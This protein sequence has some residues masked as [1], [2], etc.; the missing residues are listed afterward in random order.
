VFVPDK[1]SEAGVMPSQES[2][3]QDDEVQRGAVK[4]SVMLDG[5]GLTP[6]SKAKRVRFDGSKPTEV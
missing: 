2:H 6:T 5:R 3:R 4:A 1:N